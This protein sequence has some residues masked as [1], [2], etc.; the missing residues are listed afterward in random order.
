MPNIVIKEIDETSAGL[1]AAST[2]VV[3]IPGFAS[4][5][6]NLIIYSAASTE[7]TA[8]TPGV[9]N[10]TYATNT[11]D[12]KTW[13]CTA[14]DTSST[15]NT[16]TWTLQDTYIA[17][18][19]E[20]EPVLCLT[21]A[22]FE[23]AF[24]TTPYQFT[25]AQ[26]YVTSKYASGSPAI[27][28]IGNMYESGDYD[29]SYI[30]AKELLN[31]GIPVIYEAVTSRDSSG[32]IDSSNGTVAY[33]YTQLEGNIYENLKDKGEYTVKYLTSGAYPVY[34][35]DSNAIV[36][37]MLTCAALRGD[38]VAI[39]DHTNNSTRALTGDGSVYKALT[40]GASTYKITTYPD[41]GTMFTPWAA[42]NCPTAY[43]KDGN[44]TV[45]FSTQ[46]MPA[47]FGY[48][49]SLA[50]SVVVNPNWIAVAGVAR[51]LVPNIISLNTS[52]RLTN[53]IADSYQPRNNTSI[54][55]IT[56][57]KPYGL[58]IWGN[59]TLKANSDGNLTAT[60]FLN[61]R[62]LVSDVKKVV[63]TAAKKCMF[64]QN[65]GVLWIN[66][67]SLITPT[68]DQM[69]TGS[70]IS[71]YKVVQGKTTEK[72]KLVATIR[73][74]PVYAVEDFEITVIMSDDEVSVS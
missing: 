25:T 56:N 18:G 68:L 31:Q 69:S 36:V 26:S 39:I 33:M 41:F 40:D 63:Y 37:K 24:G 3:Y 60:S 48:L 5:N 62:N 1:N 43:Y 57:I 59:R 19:P 38:C 9:V 32:A 53:A 74:Y 58:T 2:D 71:G 50:K 16:Y 52:T 29:K 54:N 30:M 45:S 64:E 10:T 70:G 67:L 6:V 27:A 28:N 46:V 42:Y 35:Y 8:S 44:D 11:V 51:G 13:K 23:E 73:L 55:A 7:P 20:N 49:M 22:E 12:K 4:K 14:V 72:A 66:F 47:S 21:V 34:E 61:I 65:S 15:P 17:P